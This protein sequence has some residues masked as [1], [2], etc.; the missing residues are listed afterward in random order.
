M[1]VHKRSI[2]MDGL[3]FE[4]K[5]CTVRLFTHRSKVTVTIEKD[6]RVVYDEWLTPGQFISLLMRDA[7]T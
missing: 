1:K 3:C 5:A 2:P 6:G 7:R 4:H